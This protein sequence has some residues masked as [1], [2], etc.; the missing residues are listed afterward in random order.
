MKTIRYYE[1]IGLLAPT[2]ERSKSGYRLFDAQV[3]QRL[4][5]IKRAQSLGLSLEEIK[6]LLERHDQGELPCPDLKQQLQ[7]KIQA[8]AAQIEVLRTDQTELQAIIELWQDLPSNHHKNQT[9]CPN[10]QS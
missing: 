4:A 10:I 3:I 9:I 5:F 6:P 2:V 8:I 7:T 1:D